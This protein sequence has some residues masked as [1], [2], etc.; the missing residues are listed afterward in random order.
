MDPVSLDKAALKAQFGLSERLAVRILAL[1]R[2]GLGA[3]EA[4]LEEA[5]RRA[6]I[7]E[8]LLSQGLLDSAE[9]LDGAGFSDS[10]S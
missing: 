3:T 8:L 6:E 1:R 5:K 7:G 10:F 9:S 2:K 4:L